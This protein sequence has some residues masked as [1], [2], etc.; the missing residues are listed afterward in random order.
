MKT[1]GR[2]KFL[3]IGAGAGF[4]LILSA[5]AGWPVLSGNGLWYLDNPAHL[6]ETLERAQPGWQGWS[7]LAFCGFPLGQWHSPLAYGALAGAVRWGAPLVPA[8]VAA[9]WAAFVFP[10]LA[11][12]FGARSRLGAPRAT[13]LAAI[14]LLQPPALVGIE[15]AWGGMW[16]YYLAAGALLVL[17]QRWSSDR[18]SLAGD[19]AWIGGIGLIHLFVF[20]MLPLLAVLRM[21]FSFRAKTT[22]RIFGACALGALAAAA[23]WLPAGWAQTAA[24]WTPQNVSA[25]RLL[26][27]LAVPSNLQVLTSAAQIYWREAL[28]PGLLPMLALIGLGIAGGVRRI[29]ATGSASHRFGLAFALALLV[30]LLLLPLLPAGLDRICGPVSWRL[31]YLVRLGLAWSAVGALAPANAIPTSINPATGRWALARLLILALAWILAAPLR[32]AVRDPGQETRHEVQE[33]W[34]AIRAT[35]KPNDTGRI[36]L[37]D[38]YQNPA[39]PDGLAR[40]SHILAFTAA[41]T[42]A[43]QVGAYY[44]MAPQPTATWTSGEFGRLCGVAPKDP[45]AIATV[46]ERLRLAHCSRLVT[47]SPYWTGMLEQQPGFAK[48]YESDGF[49]LFRLES[50]GDPA[51]ATPA[52]PGE[53]I[54]VLTTTHSE[55][56]PLLAQSW[57][58]DWKLV[59]PG[60]A[61][62]VPDESGLCRVENLFPGDHT[63]HLRYQPPIWPRWIS[64]TVWTG[65]ALSYGRKRIRRLFDRRKGAS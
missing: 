64:W 26:W 13:L 47:A 11:L 8:Y 17:M 22:G 51:R 43:R 12:F 46:V 61:R 40:N 50:P 3:P 38:T 53:A 36:Y 65:L 27:A 19:A 60:G 16:T 34:A 20:A 23:F 42:G 52:P 59:A 62:L 48:Q 14:L 35:S 63:L 9:L 30:V 1:F 39:S 55:D 29:T 28:Q 31:L 45:E 33:L 18:G 7:D 32:H 41:A 37:Q 2:N 5:L 49:T 25:G 56:L 4:L 21:L 54:V 58:P 57:H 24:S 15:S 10:P 6:A 44:G